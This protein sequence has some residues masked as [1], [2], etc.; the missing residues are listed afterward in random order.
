MPPMSSILLRIRPSMPDPEEASANRGPI[1]MEA[2]L[3]ALHSLRGGNGRVSLE[4]GS[5]EGKVGL[6]AQ[7]TQGAAP[8]VESQLYA[9][10]PEAEIEQAPTDLFTPKN[11]EVVVSTDLVLTESEL[12]PIKR[13]PQFSDLM[14][15]QSVDTIAGVTGALVRYPLPGMRGHVTIAFTPVGGSFRRRALTFL[16]LLGKGLPKHWPAYARLFTRVHMARGWRR[17]LLLPVDILFGGFRTWFSRVLPQMSVSMLT[18]QEQAIPESDDPEHHVSMRTHEREDAVSA[19][20]DKLNRL[21]FA[22]TVRV[23]VIAPKAASAAA[24]AKVD[25]IA[26]SFRQFTL[27]Q[28]NGFIAL[29]VTEGPAEPPRHRGGSFVMSSEEIATLWHIP[30][31]L[32][33]TPNF[34]WVLSKKLE[35]PVNLPCPGVTDSEGQLTVLGEAVFHGQRMKF[36]IRTDDRRRHVYIIGKT[37]MGKS[38]LLENM[39]Y[40]DILAG[41]GVGLID[42]HGD[43][44]EAVLKFVPK[45]RSNDVVLFDPADREYPI[46]FNMLEAIHPDQRPLICSGLMSVFTKMWPDAFSG[47]MEYI[48]RNTLV[49]LLEN[50]GQSMLGILRIFA[51]DA[52]RAK[53][54][55]N[56]QEPMVKAFWQSE[57]TSWSDKYRTEAVAAIQNKIGQ[58][59]TTP[60]IR[61]IVGQVK[62]SLDIRHAM[63]TGKIVLVNL[64]KGKIGED[65]SAFIGSMLVTKFQIDAMSRADIPENDR[66]DFFLY[67]DEFQNFAT[68]SFATILSEARKY[69]LALT[70]ANQYVAQLTSGES[71]NTQLRDAVF[72]NVGTMVS[73][74]VG[75][76]DA[77]EMSMQFEE[78]VTP[79]D[80][81]SLPKFHAY[82]RLMIDGMPSKPFS[83]STLPPPQGKQDPKRLD[84]IRGLSRERYARERGE[85]EE[86]IHRWA[87]SAME[88]KAQAKDEAKRKEKEEEER[89]KAKAKGMTLEAY[90]AWRDREMWLNAFNA[91][92]KKE[93]NGEKLTVLEQT[94]MQDLV[95]KLEA[96]GGVPPPSKTMLAGKEKKDEKK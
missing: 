55:E 64:S 66:R 62:S 53:I 44:V 37:G 79:K 71:N 31:V 54:V 13:Y 10:F 92:R 91:L 94:Q 43:L 48:L 15:R 11:D 74:Q 52:Y 33:K 30:S 6:F 87:A 95:R 72:G 50:E 60:V 63:D 25:E 5:A 23:S 69:R 34:D 82:M 90:R 39:L 59:L 88:A 46:S 26:G 93:F 2:T 86:K 83:V 1:M 78:A 35:P 58:L 42:P 8:L 57:Y 49:A 51:D 9:Q 14:T 21:L 73:F 40:S 96:T 41:K 12:F 75:S 68:P 17:L 56:V 45:E 3:S 84:T 27:P 61:N 70:M 47:R 65:T 20:V 24:R 22:V 28:C 67:V 77:E 76:D 32:V 4:I 89:K 80:I 36:G 85:V 29:P 81:L 7:M 18:G 38:T 19:A 16:P